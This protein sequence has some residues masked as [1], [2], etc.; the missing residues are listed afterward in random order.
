MTVK[1]LHKINITSPVSLM[2]T[3]VET[4]EEVTDLCMTQPE[5]SVKRCL[6]SIVF[7]TVRQ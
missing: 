6:S 5:P 4:M 1:S 7:W 2:P 3:G